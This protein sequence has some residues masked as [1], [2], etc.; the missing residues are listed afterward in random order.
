VRFLIL[1]SK[2]VENFL[3]QWRMIKCTMYASN[4]SARKF[5]Q[6]C[7]VQ[8]RVSS[9]VS[10]WQCKWINTHIPHTSRQTREKFGIEFSTLLPS[11]E[12]WCSKSPK[13]LKAVIETV[14][15]I[16]IRQ[17]NDTVDYWVTVRS[18]KIKAVNTVSTQGWKLISIR[19]FHICATWRNSL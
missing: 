18:V 17:G 19:N 5:S 3:F 10:L 2:F 8:A 6:N 14:S 1:Y 7:V 13:L 15:T 4:P 12:K 9:G 16:F 11:C